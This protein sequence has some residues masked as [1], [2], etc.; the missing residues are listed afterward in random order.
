MVLIE[1]NVVTFLTNKVA[2]NAAAKLL[3]YE[4]I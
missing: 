1:A 2:I 3:N 4:G